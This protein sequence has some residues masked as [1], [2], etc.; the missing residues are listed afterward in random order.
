MPIDYGNISQLDE[1]KRKADLEVI[2]MWI[3][4]AAELGSKEQEL[5]LAN[6]LKGI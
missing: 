3:D 5:V 4:V 6:S 1:K 2:K